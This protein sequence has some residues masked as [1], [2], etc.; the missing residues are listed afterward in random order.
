MSVRL[1]GMLVAASF[2]ALGCGKT[3]AP[4]PSIVEATS[5]AT[6]PADPPT[7]ADGTAITAH[8]TIVL[9]SQGPGIGPNGAGSPATTGTGAVDAPSAPP[10]ASWPIARKITV[11]F[12]VSGA[13]FSADGA[14]LTLVGPGGLKCF[15]PGDGAPAASPTGAE[16]LKDLSCV[17]YSGDG[18]RLAVG[19][20]KL[21]DPGRIFVWDL[22]AKSEPAVLEGHQKL[23]AALAWARDGH[24]QLLSGGSD[25]LVILWDVAKKAPQ[26]TYRGHSEYV[27]SVALSPDGKSAASVGGDRI[28][29]QWEVAAPQNKKKQLGHFMT[30]N[31]VAYSP[32]GKMLASGA[33]EGNVIFWDSARG[34]Q[35][36]NFFGHKGAVTSLAFSPSGDVLATGCGDGVVRIIDTKVFKLLAQLEGHT[37]YV[38]TVAFS[39]DGRSLVSSGEDGQAILWQVPAATAAKP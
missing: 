11:G 3:P 36:H 37:D 6:T 15:S 35:L 7:G 39:R 30:I 26:Q 38:N 25:W 19:Q 10:P 16:K 23:V 32:D 29:L 13:A 17:A 9:P 4:P 22:A 12:A 5:V 31:T 21:S 24:E 2:A 14:T 34:V 8:E 28:V 33:S 18:S 1:T 27:T 20:A